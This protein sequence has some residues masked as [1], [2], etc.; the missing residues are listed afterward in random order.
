M[1]GL[2]GEAGPM[3]RRV[4]SAAC[5]GATGENRSRKEF[6]GT[7]LSSLREGAGR[8]APRVM[9]AERDLGKVGGIERKPLL[10][11]STARTRFQI[12]NGNHVQQAGRQ[13]AA[14]P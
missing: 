1:P 4:R 13:D 14:S 6:N 7:H 12:L 8:N 9:A 11:K 2:S 5:R 10:L 3:E